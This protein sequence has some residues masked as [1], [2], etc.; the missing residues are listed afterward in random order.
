MP[1]VK[2]KSARQTLKEKG[3]WEEYRKNHPY[4]PTAKFYNGG[5]ESMTNDADVSPD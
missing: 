4:N 5:T 2:G 1:L 3:L